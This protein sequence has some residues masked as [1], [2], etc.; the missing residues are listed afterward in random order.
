L[1]KR[2]E[3]DLINE[4][5]EDSIPTMPDAP[6]NVVTLMRGLKQEKDGKT[7]WHTD[8]EIRELNGEDEEYLASLEK[9]KGLTYSEYMTALLSRAVNK[10]GTYDISGE[11]GSSI[12]NKLILGDR[13]LLYLGI[14]RATYG[15]TRQVRVICPHCQVS[16]DVTLDLDEDFPVSEPDFDVKKGIV[17]STSKGDIRLRLPNGEDTMEVQKSTKSDAELN[18]MMLSRCTIWK[19]G[20]EPED[21]VRWAR[22]LN[23]KDRRKLVD[24][25]ASVEIGPKMGE[26]NTQCA[27]CEQDMPVLLDW[28]SLLLG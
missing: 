26:V 7:V 15:D 17:I 11:R 18:T 19:E 4:A 8:A 21:P 6:L 28:V 14:M 2:E 25:L 12:I 5:M 24:A 3:A 9:K 1:S 13:D 20:E 23:V 27:S 16:N 22:S 10:V